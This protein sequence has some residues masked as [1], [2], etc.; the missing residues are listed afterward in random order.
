MAF[1]PFAYGCTQHGRNC[2]SDLCYGASVVVALYSLTRRCTMD[3]RQAQAGVNGSI[4]AHAWY[5][6][7]G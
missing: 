1:I 2:F 6:A 7:V 3:H 4:P 5:V